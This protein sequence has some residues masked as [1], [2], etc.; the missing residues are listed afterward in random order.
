MEQKN[1]N[2][3][4]S[5]LSIILYIIFVLVVWYYVSTF[6]VDKENIRGLVSGYGI[7]APIIF[8]FIQ[9]GQNIIAPIAHY[10]I[11]LA[12]GFIFGPFLGFFYNWIGTSIGTILIILLAKKFG[13][14]LVRRMVSQK[15][16][17]KYDYVIQKL[18][19]FGLFLVY[20]LPIFPDDEISYLVGVSDMPVKS[21]IFAIM[22]GKIPGASLSFMGDELV[23][24]ITMTTIIQVGILIIGI[25]FYFRKNIKSLIYKK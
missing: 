23:G 17:E 2:K 7:F 8:I 5:I 21:I 14:P 13:R 11:L 15:F 3:I 1:K 22:L 25:M 12:G 18:S 6:L 10:P 20:A 9:I 19:P 4:I 24:G 16:I